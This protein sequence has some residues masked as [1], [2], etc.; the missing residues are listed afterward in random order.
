MKVIIII[1]SVFFLA[2]CSVNK[3]VEISEMDLSTDI[4]YCTNAFS[5]FNGSCNI[6]YDESD[7]IKL[8]SIYKNG[9]LDGVT[10]LFHNDGTPYRKGNYFLGQHDGL[11]EG[12]FKN[13]K[14]EFEAN[15]SNGKLEGKYIAYHSNGSIK[16][17]GEYRN[18][19]K[20][21]EWI[22]FDINGREISKTIY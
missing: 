14:K 10:T 5:P 17:Q 6:K 12:W 20:I 8:E 15:Y 3:S 2:S 9:I 21:N 22:K 16:E 7:V 11:W 1:T 4:F 19:S 18:D 13:G